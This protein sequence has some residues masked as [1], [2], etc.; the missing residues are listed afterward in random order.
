MRWELGC[1]GENIIDPWTQL[2]NRRYFDRRLTEEFERA[3]SSRTDLSVLLLEP[4]AEGQP[5][6]VGI[7]VLA[8]FAAR[9]TPCVRASD[10]LARYAGDA[11]A[12]LAPSTDAAAAWLLGERLRV[13]AAPRMTFFRLS[14]LNV[15]VATLSDETESADELMRCAVERLSLAKEERSRA[16]TYT[17]EAFAT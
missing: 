14:T 10:I 6:G 12:V 3:R 4:D 8:R 15:G 5:N 1:R 16:D 2:R 11:V 7:R 17:V 13:S 9:L